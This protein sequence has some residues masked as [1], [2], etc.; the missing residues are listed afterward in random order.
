MSNRDRIDAVRILAHQSGK[1]PSEIASAMAV[2]WNL[3][4]FH[5]AQI[6][7][8]AS[9]PPASV[10]PAATRTAAQA[11]VTRLRAESDARAVALSREHAAA[12]AANNLVHASA[13]INAH[14]H[15]IFR[16]RALDVVDHDPNDDGPIAA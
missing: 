11:A 12:K 8:L 14:S 3:S 16:G 15:D 1:S 6:A 5:A 9:A 7:H 4:P 10:V 13:L 2:A